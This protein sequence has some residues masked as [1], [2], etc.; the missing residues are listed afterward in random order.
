MELGEYVE[1]G[2]SREETFV[3]GERHLASHVGSGSARV[4]ATPSMIGFM[5]GT[6]HRLLAGRLPDG[7]SS[8]G[9]VVDVRHLAPS[10]VGSALHV[11]ADVVS[12]E[13]RRVTLRVQAWDVQESVGDGMHE[14]VVIDVASFLKRVAAKQG[15]LLG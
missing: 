2:M 12:V 14:R 1:P 8:V 5:E 11:R 4:L 10:A 7:Y 3:V 6:A 9:T 13:D 15:C